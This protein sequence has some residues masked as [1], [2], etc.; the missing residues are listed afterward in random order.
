[1]SP[2]RKKNNNN[3]YHEVGAVDWEKRR[4]EFW[5][6]IEREE[7]AEVAREINQAKKDQN[8]ERE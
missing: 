2:K 5:K 7:T 1:M 6:Q 8:N 4:L 3:K